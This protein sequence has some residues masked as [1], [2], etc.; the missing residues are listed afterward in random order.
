[1]KTKILINAALVLACV[2]TPVAAQMRVQGTRPIDPRLRNQ[3]NVLQ[4]AQTAAAAAPAAAPAAAKAELQQA[5]GTATGAGPNYPP[6][7]VTN[8]KTAG[9][10]GP[11][12]R[13]SYLGDGDAAPSAGP[14]SLD[15]MKQCFDGSISGTIANPA[16]VGYIAGYVG[17]IR[18]SSGVQGFPVCLPEGG[19]SNESIVAEVSSYLEAKPDSLQKSAR[20]VLFVVMS[21]RWPCAPG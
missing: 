6:V 3:P 16:C 13:P 4:N 14:S 15:L 10:S 5:R 17:A 19:L 1:M 2:S 12:R 20:S 18:M 7:A 21:D 11:L 9:V 8:G